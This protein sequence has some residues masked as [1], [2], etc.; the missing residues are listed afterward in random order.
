ML[1]GE[2]ASM[3]AWLWRGL[4]FTGGAVTATGAA[5]LLQTLAGTA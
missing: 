3:Q 5:F 4:R 1:I 2:V